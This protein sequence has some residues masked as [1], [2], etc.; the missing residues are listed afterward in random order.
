MNTNHFLYFPLQVGSVI[1]VELALPE[2]SS[3]PVVQAYKSGL[4]LN[5]Y[6]TDLLVTFTKRGDYILD[7]GCHLGTM[8]VPAAALGRNVVSVDASQLHVDAVQASISRN[9]LSS[10]RVL[11]YAIGESDGEVGFIEKG[12]WGMVA[13]T[14]EGSGQCRVPSRRVSTLVHELGLPRLDM[15]KMDVEGSELAALKSMGDFLVR[16]DAPVIIYESNGMTFELFGYSIADIRQ[17]L[18]E[19]G[20]RTFRVEGSR[21]VYC[22]PKQLQP[23]AWLDVIALPA[24]RRLEFTAQIDEVWDKDLFVQRCLEWGGNEHVNVRQY[25]LKAIRS[26]VDFP[27]SDER[28]MQ[29]VGDLENEFKSSSLAN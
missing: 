1:K 11:H 16:P 25:L 12:L 28:L 23:E 9:G 20:Y 19:H 26:D 10:L 29:L 8:S 6:L 4:P 7:L 13:Q 5:Q 14:S 22:A 17:F 21:F 3:D 24:S 27:N 15:V 18:E 2:D